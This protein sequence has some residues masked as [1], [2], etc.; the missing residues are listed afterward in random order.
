M[1]YLYRPIDMWEIPHSESIKI[2]IEERKPK[3]S[4]ISEDLPEDNICY[5]NPLTAAYAAISLN[6]RLEKK[7]KYIICDSQGAVFLKTKLNNKLL[8][9]ANNEYKT[10]KKCEVCNEI[11]AVGFDNVSASGD[12]CSDVCRL[13]RAKELQ[14]ALNDNEESEFYL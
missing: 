11:L 4:L 8:D 1:Y 10:L 6:K 13:K 14:E 9:W 7:L 12:P 5:I 2:S 3:L